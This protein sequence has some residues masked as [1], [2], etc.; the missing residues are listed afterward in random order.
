MNGARKAASCFHFSLILRGKAFIAI[1]TAQDT[2]NAIVMNH[3]ETEMVPEFSGPEIT[4]SNRISDKTNR[5]GGINSFS[6][7]VFAFIGWL[8]VRIPVK[9]AGKPDDPAPPHVSM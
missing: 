7:I 1:A 9:N 6:L 8:L 5:T 2:A 4:I 3:A